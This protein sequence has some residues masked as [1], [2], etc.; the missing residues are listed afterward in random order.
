[1]IPDEIKAS[2]IDPFAYVRRKK[3][4]GRKIVGYLMPDVPAEIVHAAGATPFLLSGGPTR[5]LAA[6]E[7]LQTYAC[8]IC[9]RSLAWALEGELDFL[10]GMVLPIVCDTSRTLAHIWRRNCNIPFFES[11]L[12]PR[13]RNC[14]EARDYLRNELVRFKK[15]L[16]DFL[17]AEISDDSLRQSIS[18]YNEN[19]RM[20][21]EFYDLREQNRLPLSNAEF[22]HVVRSSFVIAKENH[23][24]L[25]R[26]L[27]NS[28]DDGE[29]RHSGKA[30]RQARL[31][32]SGKVAEPRDLF[33]HLDNCGYYIVGDDFWDGF[34]AFATDPAESD[35]PLDA[36]TNNYLSRV[37]FPVFLDPMRKR[38]RGVVEKVREL[39]VDGVLFLYPKYCEPLA[40]DYPEIRNSLQN[41]GI[42]SH[43][44][45]LELDQGLTND[46]R[47]HLDT[48]GYMV[49]TMAKG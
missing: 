24:R 36:M 18:V 2:A 16:E 30:E 15:R 11:L 26:E 21:R 37:P 22:Y 5:T 7:H 41:E 39:A 32:L 40:F 25:L 1:M 47:E 35:D 9:R 8:S 38:L 17:K 49:K 33:G 23:N 29:E 28:M 46:V 43:L 3:S 10:D 42:P 27:L 19:R 31:Y 4:E 13:I 6:E 45:E 44:I 14:P 20:M 12:V 48:Y 34:T